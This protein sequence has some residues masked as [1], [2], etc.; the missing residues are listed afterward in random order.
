MLRILALTLA[1]AT[2]AAA[3]TITV[4]AAASLQGPV[5]AVAAQWQ[6]TTGNVVR[7][8]YAGTAQLARQIE[9]GAPADVFLAASEDWMD[10][11]AA[12]GLIQPATRVT[13]AGNSLVLIGP[14]QVPPAAIPAAL[15]ALGD[16]KLAMALVDSVPAGQYGR[17]A[18]ENL[19]LWA[20][21][22]PRVAQADNVRAALALVATGEAPLGIVYATDARAEPRVG[23]VATF[24]EGSHTPIVY[25]GALTAAA[26]PAAQDF[27]DA[28]S[29]PD[30]RAAFA[31][32]GF[33][34]P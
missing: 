5:D 34:A 21:V 23:V 11:L 24:P 2:P 32:A 13:L 15:D 19:G 14:G 6:E 12:K 3:E 25:P 30:G 16:G 17:Q 26:K 10:D 8:S 9:Q 31:A 33:T 28:L 7:I 27:L 20:A 4:F 18:L 22:A 29:G 1:L